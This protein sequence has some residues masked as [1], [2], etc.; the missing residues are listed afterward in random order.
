MKRL[1]LLSITIVFFLSAKSQ[2][3]KN[4]WLIGGS[5]KL[6][7]YTTTNYSTPNSANTHY[8]EISISPSIGYFVADR[9]AF[10][11]RPTF[12]S[13]KKRNV[14]PDDVLY[15][16]KRYLIGPFG[17]YYFLDSERPF[18]LLMELCYQYGIPDAGGNNGKLSTFSALTGPVIYFNNTVG[19]EVLMGYSSRM[20]DVTNVYYEVRKGFQLAIGFQIHL[21]YSSE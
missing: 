20:E 18:N 12:S 14:E 21:S 17:R 8:T 13:L 11:L 3:A 7:S 1:L 10:G 5:G 16:Y 15:N 6:Y 9:V 19:L 2:L 4:D